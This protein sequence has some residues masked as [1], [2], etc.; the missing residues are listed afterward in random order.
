MA[1][2]RSMQTH[3]TFSLSP[4]GKYMNILQINSSA[5]KSGSTSTQLANQLTKRLLAKHLGATAQVL[6]LAEQPHPLVDDAIITALATP[7]DERTADQ[8]ARVALD[9][10]LIAQIQAA[11]IVVLGVP[12]YNLNI[13]IQLKS[14]ID[15]I[16][17]PGTTYHYTETGREGLLTGKKVYVAQ[18]RGGI[19]RD[20]PAD[21][22]TPYIKNVFGL[23]GMTDVKFIYAEGLLYGDEVRANSLTQAQNDI[24]LLVA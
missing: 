1:A 10:A 18:T 23:V 9:D 17:R 4:K 15:A 13:S 22:Q 5:R 11:D 21:T 20:T 3:L 12:M 16:V 6:D 19:Y 8:A 2:I 14:W 7:A 24:E